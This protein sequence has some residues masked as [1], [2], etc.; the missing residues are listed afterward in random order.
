MVF[1]SRCRN[2]RGIL[3]IAHHMLL[4]GSAAIDN[5]HPSDPGSGGNACTDTDQRGIARPLDG[6]GN[7]GPRC[8]IGA[9]EAPAVALVPEIF[10]DGF[11][12]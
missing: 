5:G 2:Y 10:A 1:D 9:I 11:E 7:A 6:N 8:D 4:P 3:S 12:D